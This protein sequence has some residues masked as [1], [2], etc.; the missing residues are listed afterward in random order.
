M[1]PTTPQKTDEGRDARVAISPSFY[2]LLHQK[3]QQN[4]FRTLQKVGEIAT[5][6]TLTFTLKKLVFI[7][8]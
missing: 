8:F 6:A 2:K 5:L 7:C 3:K 1:S 4:I